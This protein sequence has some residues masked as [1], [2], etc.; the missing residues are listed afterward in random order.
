VIVALEPKV[1]QG[2]VLGRYEYRFWSRHGGAVW[3]IMFLIVPVSMEIYFFLS[4]IPGAAEAARGHG[5]YA[6]WWGLWG[7]FI[8]LFLYA[9][10]RFTTLLQPVALTEVGIAASIQRLDFEFWPKH[11]FGLMRWDEIERIE[12]IRWPHVD[13]DQSTFKPS[14]LRIVTGD[15]KIVIHRKIKGYSELCSTLEEQMRKH[16]K[17]LRVPIKRAR[18]DF[19]QKGQTRLK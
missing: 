6:A 11:K 19:P 7:F 12:L 1:S 13:A 5:V 4:P 10:K 16:G 14:A 15:R 8:V 9:E 18:F 3:A 2:K 17:S